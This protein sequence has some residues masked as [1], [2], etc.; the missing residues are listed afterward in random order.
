MLHN[1]VLSAVLRHLVISTYWL[2]IID[3]KVTLKH[4]LWVVW[5]SIVFI[6]EIIINFVA[7]CSVNVL[8][9]LPVNTFYKNLM[10][11]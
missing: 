2:V 4:V 7:S 9:K 3:L 1:I 11:G 6:F 5:K 10:E 8:Y